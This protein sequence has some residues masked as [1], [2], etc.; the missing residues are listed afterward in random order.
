[1]YICFSRKLFLHFF[2]VWIV[3]VFCAEGVLGQPENVNQYLDDG[4]LTNTFLIAK[5]DLFSVTHGDLSALAELR[6]SSRLSLELGGGPMLFTS[7]SL[8]D[9]LI[10]AAPDLSGMSNG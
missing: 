10:E 5:A 6:I 1:M 9:E 8:L 2:C 4:G 3:G 7:N